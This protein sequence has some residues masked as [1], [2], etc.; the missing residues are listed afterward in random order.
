MRFY[1]NVISEGKRRGV[2]LIDFLSEEN[3]SRVIIPTNTRH[4]SLGRYERQIA[5]NGAMRTRRF[6]KSFVYR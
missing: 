2:S 3:A 5:C 4:V 6:M 1:R